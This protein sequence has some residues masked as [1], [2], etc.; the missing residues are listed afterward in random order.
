MQRGPQ[1]KNKGA[2]FPPHPEGWGLHAVIMMN[3]FKMLSILFVVGV[4]YQIGF[5]YFLRSNTLICLTDSL[6]EYHTLIMTGFFKL[7]GIQ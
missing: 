2:A 5:D 6:C 4:I 7:F 3:R 1:Q